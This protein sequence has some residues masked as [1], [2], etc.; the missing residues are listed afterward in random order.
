[1]NRIIDQAQRLF[2]GCLHIGLPVVTSLPKHSEQVFRVHNRVGP[3]V[4][5]LPKS[6]VNLEEGSRET[7][8]RHELLLR[9]ELCLNA[10]QSGFHLA[11]KHELTHNELEVILKSLLA[12]SQSLNDFVEHWREITGWQVAERWHQLRHLRLSQDQVRS[13]LEVPVLQLVCAQ[14]STHYQQNLVQHYR[15]VLVL[16]VFFWGLKLPLE[17]F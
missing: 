1:M 4:K 14:I 11:I 5:V 15:L 17:L 7:V 6:L 2:L 3:K 10:G 12:S 13:Q 16:Q 8:I 9:I